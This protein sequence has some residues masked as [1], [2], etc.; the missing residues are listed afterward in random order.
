MRERRAE[1]QKL[2]TER[3][4]KTHHAKQKVKKRE[5]KMTALKA[6][7]W[8]MKIKMKGTKGKATEARTETP[9]SSRWSKHRAH[10]KVSNAMPNT[11]VKKARLI[12]KLAS[13]PRTRDI[14]RSKG[15]ILNTSVKQKIQT[16]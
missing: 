3:A 16:V 1:Q 9:F 14:L 12:E 5:N 15:A 13:S 2:C 7:S 10:K 11:P 6:N 8:R 4:R